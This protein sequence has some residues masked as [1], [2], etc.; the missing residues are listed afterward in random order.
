MTVRFRPVFYIING[1]P[2]IEKTREMVD[3]Y[4]EHGVC[5]LQFDMPSADPSRE[6]EFIQERMKHARA[7]YGEGYDVYMDE[8]RDIR[9]AYPQLEIHLVLYPDV[10]ETIGLERFAD[11]CKEIGVFSVLAMQPEMMK[12]LNGRGIATATFIGYDTSEREIDLAKA[13]DN[14]IVFLSN[15]NGRTQP[16][17]G[18]ETWAQ[19]VKY[20]REAGVKAPVFGVTGISTAEELREVRD[21]GAD[22]AY[23]GTIMMKLWDHE[24]E[25]W[26]KLDDFQAVAE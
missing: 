22:G 24:E 18:L 3:K 7:L 10:I 13:N 12:Y 1:W 16:R 8:L 2:S 9:A 23:I 21:A 5:A 20:I 6:S 26:K 19:R 15:K 14:Q 25:L 11:F 17:D 4:V